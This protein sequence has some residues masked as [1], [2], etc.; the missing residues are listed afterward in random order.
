MSTRSLGILALLTIAVVVGAFFTSRGRSFETEP[1]QSEPLVPELVSRVN[2]VAEIEITQS[3]P[4]ERRILLARRDDAWVDASRG[5][6]PARFE[7]VKQLLIALS[8][9]EIIER[10][11]SN[12]EHY[13]RL[14]VGDPSVEGDTG[15]LVR[16]RDASG[17]EIVAIVIG[18]PTDARDARF[19][20]HLDQSEVVLATGNLEASA[21][22][23]SWL[24]REIVRVPRD[25]VARVTIVRPDADTFTIVRNDE[26]QYDLLDVPPGRR[27][28]A[29]SPLSRL[30]GALA[31]VDL[32]NVMPAADLDVESLDAPL[33]AT[34]VTDDAT[35]I[36]VSVWNDDGRKWA[37]FSFP[38]P[39]AGEPG[40]DSPAAES[41]DAPTP[42]IPAPFGAPVDD[43]RRRLDGWLFEGSPSA[44]VPLETPMFELTEEI[45]PD[46]PETPG[47][48][49]APPGPPGA[50]A[51]D[52]PTPDG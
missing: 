32:Q 26:G 4:E 42:A 21:L 1:V 29:Q 52:P 35:E 43:L 51:A 10:K 45:P 27:V 30:A 47:P 16:L 23:L 31:Y 50:G 39:P 17:D 22:P 34:Y 44:L 38:E 2:D 9:S 41:P 28:R 20:R 13:A 11:T 46:P 6:Y 3:G 48:D 24:E 25:Q 49:A 12:P 36:N 5:G 15:T 8:E 7:P 14:G 19:V 18:Q 37:G 33:L 40:D